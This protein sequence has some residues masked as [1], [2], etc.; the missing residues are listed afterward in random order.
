MSP[1]KPLPLRSQCARWLWQSASP[2]LI[3]PLPK[4][5]STQAVPCQASV[6]ADA[7]AR[8]LHRIFCN[9]SLRGRKAPVAIRT[10]YPTAKIHLS[11]TP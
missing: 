5:D 6:G 2:V 3:G 11:S 1:V 7:S 4:G 8:P 9:V 10:P